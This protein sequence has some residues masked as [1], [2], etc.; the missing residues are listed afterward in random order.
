V[1]NVPP[2]EA[3]VMIA[4]SML[5]IGPAEEYLFRGFM[6]G[7]LLSMTKGKHWLPLAV[8]SS[9]LFAFSHG[10]YLLTYQEASPVFFIQI[11]AFGLGMCIT[12]YW[13]GGNLVALA[14]IHGLIDVI[15]FLGV[16]TSRTVAL[17]AQSVFVAIGLVFLFLYVAKKITLK[18]MPPAN[19]LAPPQMPATTP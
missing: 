18:P 5:V 11:I 4:V 9:L 7:G 13:S 15:G 17:A 12:Y 14:V 3:L 10:Y 6:Y 19:E 1:L 8:V 2:A 16:A